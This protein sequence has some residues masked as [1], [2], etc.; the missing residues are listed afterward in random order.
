MNKICLLVGQRSQYAIPFILNLFYHGSLCGI[1]YATR[2]HCI[3]LITLII[4]PLDS[5]R[6]PDFLFFE[7]SYCPFVSF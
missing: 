7:M 3:N 1:Q 5:F 2:P 6:L 4:K